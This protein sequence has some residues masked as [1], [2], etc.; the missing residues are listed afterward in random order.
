MTTEQ[1]LQF[2]KNLQI[3]IDSKP[4][5]QYLVEYKNELMAFWGLDIEPEE[6]IENI[7]PEEQI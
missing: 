2:I 5:L 3:D 4:N 6:Q 7:E 1:K